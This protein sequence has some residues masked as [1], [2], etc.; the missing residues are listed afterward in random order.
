VVD[1]LETV[2]DAVAETTR[3]TLQTFIERTQQVIDQTMRRVFNEESVPAEDKLVSLFEPHTAI[4]KRGKAN[5]PTEFGHKVWLDEVDGGIVSDYR[6][7]EGNPADS[8]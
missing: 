4:I 2:G 3:Q 6:I 8:D 7:L 5:R 1:R